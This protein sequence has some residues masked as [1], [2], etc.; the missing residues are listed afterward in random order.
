MPAVIIYWQLDTV[1]LLLNIFI[2]I[3]CGGGQPGT[4][5]G[6]RYIAFALNENAK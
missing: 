5:S 1:Y 4:R 3:A 6:D 2:V